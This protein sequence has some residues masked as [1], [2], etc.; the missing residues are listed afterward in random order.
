MIELTLRIS[1][2]VMEVEIE[3]SIAGNNNAFHP[4]SHSYDKDLTTW[5]QP[6]AI[7]GNY[8]RLNLPR[9][10]HVTTVKVTSRLNWDYPTIIGT[11]VT[12]KLSP[13][14]DSEISDL[15]FKCGTIEGKRAAR[16]ITSFLQSPNN[17]NKL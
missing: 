15:G 7:A 11:E 8:I 14:K 3:S 2:Q 1:A 6:S 9:R 4:A 13:E 10:Y 5:Y 12:V 17:V 16:V